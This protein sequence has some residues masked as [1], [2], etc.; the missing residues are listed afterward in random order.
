MSKK[1]EHD[2]YVSFT[3]VFLGTFMTL[4]FW[5]FVT[6]LEG[7]DR[8]SVAAGGSVVFLVSIALY[9]YGRFLRKLK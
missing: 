6:G 5:F 9:Y 8:F 1:S 2:L 7:M 3:A 4:G